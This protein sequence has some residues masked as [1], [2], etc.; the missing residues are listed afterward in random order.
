MHKIQVFFEEEKNDAESNSVKTSI[1]SDLEIKTG[2][3]KIVNC[4]YINA[5][6]N[7]EELHKVAGKLFADPI[8]QK[9]SVDSEP[10]I[11]FDWLIEVKLHSGVTDN[12][13]NAAV[14]GVQDLIKRKFRE[15]ET[16]RASKKYFISGELE[17]KQ[18][19]RICTEMLA[20]TLIESTE[21]KKSGKD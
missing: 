11:S 18:I 17:E 20:N 8:V 10:E 9:Y 3:L 15:N 1:E 19:K 13:G 16:I 21:Y 12:I 14:I 7:E 2:S 4:Y 6:L 5:E